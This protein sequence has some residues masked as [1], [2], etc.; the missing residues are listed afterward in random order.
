M[1]NP[2]PSRKN[3]PFPWNATLGVDLAKSPTGDYSVVIVTERLERFTGRHL[4]A[5]PWRSDTREL[6]SV[7]IV[8]HAERFSRGTE[9]GQVVRRCGEILRTPE[10]RWADLAFDRTGLGSAVEEQFNA[11]YRVDQLGEGFPIGY[12]FTSGDQVNS[13][14]PHN[15]PKRV[16]A[17]D[18]LSTAQ[19]GR[20]QVPDALPLADLIRSELAEFQLKLTKAGNDTYEAR[21]GHDD[22]VAALALSVHH[23]HNR[24]VPRGLNADGTITER[25]H[26]YA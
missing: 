8:R 6:E 2:L 3:H 16:L 17:M 10:L 12:T 9:F 18:L 13:G 21:R 11:A 7:F 4:P 26:L 19:Q 25:D 20:L 1:T 22:T 23:T 5:T 14:K 15:V 24:V